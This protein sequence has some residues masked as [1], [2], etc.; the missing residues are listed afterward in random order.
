MLIMQVDVVKVTDGEMAELA[1]PLLERLDW[2]A[3]RAR[4]NDTL[5]TR[6]DAYNLT[7]EQNQKYHA[8]C[9]QYKQV[10]LHLHLSQMLL[11]VC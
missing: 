6:E 7:A 1:V 3:D 11:A 9:E 4:Q 2:E 5:M 8:Y 10:G